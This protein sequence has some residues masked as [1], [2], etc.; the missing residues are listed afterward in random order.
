MDFMSDIA[1]IFS[2]LCHQSVERSPHFHGE[3][4]PLCFR[5]SGIYLGIFSTYLSL[6]ISGKYLRAPSSIKEI[7]FLSVLFLPLMIDGAANALSIW[8]SASVVRAITG[9]S[10]GIFLATVLIPYFYF[11]GFGNIFS[12]KF[13]PAHFVISFTSG[14][15]LIALLAFPS[16]KL[17]F[18][19]L[20]LLA[21]SG[22][23]L[24]LMNIFLFWKYYKPSVSVKEI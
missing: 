8:N 7:L 24:L 21:L 3:V 17:V 11:Y 6:L 1:N 15:I 12:G 14:L 13:N 4:F 19:T 16:G 2:F 20:S 9:L 23:I 5:C 18:N 10:A 22:F